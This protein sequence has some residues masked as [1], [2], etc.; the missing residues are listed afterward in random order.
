LDE[1][2]FSA[3]KNPLYKRFLLSTKDKYLLHHIGK[4][5]PQETVLTRDEYEIRLNTLRE[6]LMDSKKD[7]Q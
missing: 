5:N 1:L 4:E 6:F 3:A 2:Y 7:M